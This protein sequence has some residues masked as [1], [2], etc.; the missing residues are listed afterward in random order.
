MT[1]TDSV[2]AAKLRVTGNT[3]LSDV[4]ADSLAS[5]QIRNSETIWTDSLY[6]NKLKLTGTLNVDTAFVNKLGA[7][8]FT[9]Q[10]INATDSAKINKLNVPGASTLNTVTSNTI[11][12]SGNLSTAT[13]T[14]T[15]SVLAAKLRVTGNSVLNDVWAD[16][17]ASRQIRNSETIWTDSL[18]VNKLKLTGTLNVDT[19][20]VN[21]LG[22][23]H[24]TTQWINATDSAKINKLNVP[25][26]STLNTVTSNTIT[27]SGN[28]STATMTATDS[29]LAA[30][31]RV[32]GNSVLNDVW[33]DS[34]ASRQIRNSE[35]IWTDSLYVNKL[36]LSGTLNVDTAF[37]NKLG[38]NH[39]TTQWIN[40][41]DS[42]KI[43]KL[44]VPGASTLN[45]VTSN[46]ISNS[47]N[48]ST[49]TM[50]ATDSVLS[51]K[52]RVTGNSVLNDVWA[53]SLA[54]RQ[55]RNS[56]TIWTDSLYVNK[57]KLSG[58]LNVDTAFVN[59]LGANHFTTQWI[60][61]TDSAKI[62]KLNVPGASTLHA[63]S[64]TGITNVGHISTTTLAASDS[65]LS[66]KLR[67]T[68]GTITTLT[69]DSISTRALRA[70]GTSSLNTVTSN[71]L[72]NSGLIE[73]STLKLTGISTSSEDTL[74][75]VNSAGTV[76][77]RASSSISASTSWTLVG[78]AGTD[79]TTNYLGT[80]DNSPVVMKTNGTERMRVSR[81]GN[82]GIGTASPNTKLHV[83]AASDP[84]TLT[85]V[86]ND[87]SVDTVIA[88]N[89]SGVVKKRSLSSAVS[90]GMIK[91]SYV[92][93][94]SGST[95]T[96]SPGS[97]IVSGAVVVVTMQ[98][99]AASGVISAMV[100]AVNAG[101]DSF[102]VST[103]ATINASYSI[104]Y[105]IINP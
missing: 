94:T 73:S 30:K 8:H 75:V 105:I 39:F 41:T 100:T 65:I 38:A 69:A 102:T 59:K 90:A 52:L 83:S 28:L 88:I 27:N 64:S 87:N 29:V 60:N 45:T 9:T 42:A 68:T 32:T 2:L 34:L 82:V 43:N 12:N 3:V 11:T 98:G 15:D 85:G 67:A 74:L 40:A 99:S 53:D 70:S 5:R 72:T 33:A 56:E 13:M 6:V 23:N 61:A 14:A 58:T 66:N 4:W 63:V 76:S 77:K 95:F 48:L 86:Q 20:F 44:N 50:T 47:G 25:G 92:P 54:S 21:K 17:L 49:A 19:A 51:A 1:A 35:T 101:A 91:G 10:W 78:N 57:L 31:L 80:S 89:S 93:G 24:F 26:A 84:L 96:I 37:V 97:D 62:S 46:T 71:S 36:K 18:Y 55:I 103:S 79:S 22:A 104:N 7:N 16:S 81:S